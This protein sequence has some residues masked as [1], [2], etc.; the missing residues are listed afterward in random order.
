MSWPRYRKLFDLAYAKN[1]PVSATS[2]QGGPL[3][4]EMFSQLRLTLSGGDVKAGTLTGGA[5]CGETPHSLIKSLFLKLN[6]Q[7]LIEI[8]GTDLRVVHLISNSKDVQFT[9]T[10]ATTDVTTAFRAVYNFDF[11]TRLSDFAR[12]TFLAANRYDTVEFGVQWGSETDFH[13]GA[14]ATSHALTA[15]TKLEVEGEMFTGIPAFHVRTDPN[16]GVS[17]PVQYWHRRFQRITFPIS[18]TQ[19]AMEFAIPTGETL[20]RIYLKEYTDADSFE[21]PRT[22]IIDA[23]GAL[24]LWFN[25]SERKFQFSKDKLDELSN[26]DY[27]LG[28]GTATAMPTGYHVLDF[29]RDRDYANAMRTDAGAGISAVTIKADCTTQSNAKVRALLETLVQSL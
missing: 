9:P 13:S 28:I 23:A 18:Q 21:T 1:L 12:R 4:K 6:G 3:T 26:D 10:V 20:A 22:N 16:T 27:R 14:Y 11:M 17:S 7:Q 25:G 15:A 5:L 24:E 2:S 19:K 29:M 8:P